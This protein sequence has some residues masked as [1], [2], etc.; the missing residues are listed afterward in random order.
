MSEADATLRTY[1]LTM[2]DR[3]EVELL[4]L[5]QIG[6]MGPTPTLRPRIVEGLVAGATDN[7]L[8]VAGRHADSRV[9]WAAIAVIRPAV[10]P[11][12]ATT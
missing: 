3:V 12:P 10:T 11:H 1:G 4:V 2:G 8:I 7:V 6:A 9:R 5:E